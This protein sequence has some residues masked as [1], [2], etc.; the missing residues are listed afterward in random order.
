[1]TTICSLCKR[2]GIQGGKGHHNFLENVKQHAGGKDH[3]CL[4][5][6]Q[7][8]NSKGMKDIM[9][10]FKPAATQGSSSNGGNNA[11]NE[12]SGYVQPKAI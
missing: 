3:N 6:K 2:N 12:V 11:P 9:N 5:K 4:I 10:F 1:M 7:E 8:P